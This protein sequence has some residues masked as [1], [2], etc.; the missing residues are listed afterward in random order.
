MNK[1]IK[2]NYNLDIIGIIKVSEKVYRLKTKDNKYYCF[3]HLD[4]DN[5]SIFAHLSL[6]N[7]SSFSMPIKTNNN[8]FI[9]EINNE[10]YYLSEWY[11]DEMILAK[12]IRL[13]FFFDELIRLHKESM[14]DFK[15]NKGYF[16]EI[17]LMLEKAI[18]D[19]EKE[20]ETYLSSIEK[21]EYKSPSEWLF[22][23][24]NNHFKDAINKSKEHLK[25]FKES[26]KDLDIIRVSL[27]YLN[28][29]FSNIIVKD[30]KIIGTEKM[31]IAPFIYDIKEI[32]DK[33]YNLSIDIMAFIKNYFNEINLFEYE[34]DWLLAILSLPLIDYSLKDEVDKIINISKINYHINRTIEIEKLIN[35]N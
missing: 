21:L 27:V 3:K 30:K 34:R 14:Y 4:N 7:I 6:L 26:T 5:E 15:I 11:N 19:E 28:F 10:F 31:K 16:E 23:M 17:L 33:S 20:F 9:I 29:D 32:F 12:E 22:I 13:K 8:R 25:K 24:N 35:K 1:S 2:E 18:D